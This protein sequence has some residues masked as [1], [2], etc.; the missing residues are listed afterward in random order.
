ME[1]NVAL[2]KLFDGDMEWDSAPGYQCHVTTSPLG[3]IRGLVDELQK[4]A[5]Q[6]VV[7]RP[8]KEALGP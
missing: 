4:D 7:Q 8:Y 6:T 5:T 1:T 2:R 3:N